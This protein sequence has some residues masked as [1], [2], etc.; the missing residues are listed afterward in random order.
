MAKR[1]PAIFAAA[2]LVSLVP[3]SAQPLT[4]QERESLLTHLRVLLLSGHSARHTAQILEVKDS[5]GYPK[6]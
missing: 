6:P 1:L 2:F 5:P 3:A 4:Q